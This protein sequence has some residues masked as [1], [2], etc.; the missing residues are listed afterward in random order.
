MFGSDE[1]SICICI[2]ICIRRTC[3]DD[4]R[5]S[6]WGDAL[7]NCFVKRLCVCLCVVSPFSLDNRNNVSACADGSSVGNIL[8]TDRRTHAVL[9]LK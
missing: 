3:G 7:E 8:Q 6:P 1:I 4:S 9:A 5:R 2:C